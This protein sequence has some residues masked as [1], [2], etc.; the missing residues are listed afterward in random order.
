[1]GDCMENGQCVENACQC[2][3]GFVEVDKM[4]NKYCLAYA[5]L[6]NEYACWSDEQCSLIQDETNPDGAPASCTLLSRTCGCKDPT[7][8][9]F[10]TEQDEV[11]FCVRGFGSTC[12]SDEQCQR[13]IIDGVCMENKCTCPTDYVTLEGAH[14][15]LPYAT[16]EEN[17]CMVDEQCANMYDKFAPS[18]F[19]R[20]PKCDIETEMCTCHLDNFA[21]FNST[22]VRGAG[23]HC[24]MG[25]LRK[26]GVEHSS[27][28]LLTRTCNCDFGY[29]A[30]EQTHLCEWFW[31]EQKEVA[32][33]M[34][35]AMPGE[36]RP[37]R[38]RAAPEDV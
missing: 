25:L 36:A 6:E 32:G 22:C 13:S 28:H 23:A 35:R 38:K 17:H 18:V 24:G 27:C 29:K 21:I 20:H 37:S 1:M 2:T 10:E 11:P 12:D 30:N 16:E 5:S 26:C 4:F 15:C 31:E 33:A 9:P 3:D 14:M 34:R 7:W 8:Y 19:S